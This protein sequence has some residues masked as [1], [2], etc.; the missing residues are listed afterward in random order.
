V[1]LNLSP[2]ESLFLVFE[3]GSS[4][5]VVNSNFRDILEVNQKRVLALA[6]ENGTHRITIDNNGRQMTHSVTVM[7]I[8]APFAISGTWR[9]VL[10]GN[11][12]ATLDTTLTDLYSWVENP[13]TK[14]FSGTGRYEIAFELPEDY[15]GPDKL[16]QL[17]LGKVGNIAEVELNGVNV[18]AIW[19]RGHTLD[20]TN[21]VRT[22][23]NHLEV[24]VTNTLINR[25]SNF[26]APQPIPEHLVPLYGKSPASFSSRI[27]PEIGF[28]PLPAS[29]LLGPVKIKVLKKVNVLIE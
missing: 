13:R 10:E 14:H 8:P 18:G 2:Y 19:M 3:S 9:M 6:G 7:G 17:D 5:H 15:W 1:P 26:Q 28:D 27:P 25:V 20:I 4:P 21:A 22:G 11:G 23:S 16:L 29:G 12:F 24:F